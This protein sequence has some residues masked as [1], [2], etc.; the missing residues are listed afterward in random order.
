M[1][2][3]SER[4]V[5]LL[6]DKHNREFALLLLIYAIRLKGELPTTIS[7]T[8][9]VPNR[10]MSGHNKQAVEC[11]TNTQITIEEKCLRDDKV[12]LDSDGLIKYHITGPADQIDRAKE[13]IHMSIKGDKITNAEFT[14]KFRKFV[15]E[16][17]TEGYNFTG[18]SF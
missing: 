7:Q 16:L 15:G 18:Q 2:S 6:A 9:E 10:R 14:V 12:L 8:I 1:L 3:Y 5:I 13:L 4:C 11:F 17:V